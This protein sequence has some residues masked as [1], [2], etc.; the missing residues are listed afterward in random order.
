M[1]QYFLLQH[2]SQLQ[3]FVN[4]LLQLESDII[5]N[6]RQFRTIAEVKLPPL[7][8]ILSIQKFQIFLK[9][10]ILVQKLWIFFKFFS[11]EFVYRQSETQKVPKNFE[12]I[13]IYVK[14]NCI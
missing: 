6:Q 10:E 12:F 14:T 13:A 7:F 1:Q 5:S 2:F 9:N 11:L 4:F 8:W 3:L